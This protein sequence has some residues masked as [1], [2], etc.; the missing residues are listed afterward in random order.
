MIEAGLIAALGC[1]IILWRLGIRRVVGY[2]LFWDIALTT[3]LVFMFIGTYAGMM[4]GLFAG[5]I[6]SVVLTLVK[7]SIG[8]ERLILSRKKGKV[9][10]RAK[11]RRYDGSL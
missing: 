5:V 4:T 8:Y 3:L 10:P 11:W 7:K 9:F 6:I 2:I 1:L